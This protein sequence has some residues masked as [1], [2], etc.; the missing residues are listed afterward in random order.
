[1]ATTKNTGT[2]IGYQRVSTN[3]QDAQLQANALAEAGC[4]RIFEDKASGKN[5]DRAGLLAALDYMREG[6]TLTVWKLDRLGRSTKDV[7]TIA[8][9]LHARGIALR[10]LTGTLAGSY[11]P[12]GEGKFFFTMM[13]AFA[14]LERDMIVERTRAGLDAAKAQGR[15][16]GRPSVMDADKLV[17]ARARKVK[18]ESVTAIAKAL[19]VSRATLYRALADAE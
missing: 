14:E 12:K 2:L 17:A 10:I 1:M 3:A 15:T 5:V 13:V 4:A 9:D 19:K 11:S 16:G 8:E 7:L 18:G 6:D